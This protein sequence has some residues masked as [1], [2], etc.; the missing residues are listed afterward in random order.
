MPVDRCVLAVTATVISMAI[1]DKPM[2]MPPFDWEGPTSAEDTNRVALAWIRLAQV[3]TDDH[4][5]TDRE[6]TLSTWLG[7]ARQGWAWRGMAWRGKAGKSRRGAAGRARQGKGGRGRAGPGEA[8]EGQGY[9]LL[10][11]VRW[12]QGDDMRHGVA[13]P[14]RGQ[15]GT[16]AR[17][18]ARE[19][20]GAGVQW[21]LP[22]LLGSRW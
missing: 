14:T 16:Q 19:G 4:P 21:V 20:R 12:G 2:A 5:E 11:F 1:M 17:S 18:L 22:E 13:G 10:A 7:M 3:A 8:G 6:L 15:E 9:G